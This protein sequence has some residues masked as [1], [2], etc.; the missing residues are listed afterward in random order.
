LTADGTAHRATVK[1][2]FQAACVADDLDASGRAQRETASRP[3]E[4]EC[5]ERLLGLITRAEMVKFAK[6]GSD[7]TTA[8]VK[9]ARAVTGRD[10]VAVCCDQPLLSVDDWFLAI[11]PMTAGIPPAVREL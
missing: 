7:A 3:I 5:A 1:L 11:T 9:L 10:L 2:E 6:N 4:V 8:A